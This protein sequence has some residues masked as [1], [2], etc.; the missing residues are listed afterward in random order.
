M[1]KPKS[2][3]IK[4]LWTKLVTNGLIN[5]TH[6]QIITYT[7][8]LNDLKGFWCRRA[9]IFCK[10]GQS[11]TD[12]VIPVLLDNKFISAILIQVKNETGN[13]DSR[14]LTSIYDKSCWKS[15]NM[16]TNGVKDINHIIL[17]L[18]VGPCGSNEP[19]I[20]GRRACPK[21]GTPHKAVVIGV[22]DMT[23][24]N[25]KIDGDFEKVLQS[26]ARCRSDAYTFI[27]DKE[28]RS[29]LKRICLGTYESC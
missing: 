13:K 7:P 28:R 8:S 17:Y 19:I 26:L 27:E 15:A 23:K 16:D 12:L 4:D 25:Y 3:Q 6:F 9:A 22:K 10:I 18:Q 14:S 11:G 20:A 29:I 21:K 24:E 1:T 2:T 5:F